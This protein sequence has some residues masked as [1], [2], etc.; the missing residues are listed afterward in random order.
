MKTLIP[1]FILLILTGCVPT[2][3][4]SYDISTVESLQDSIS[5]NKTF[6]VF[7]F[8]DIREE[9]SDTEI[10]FDSG[11]LYGSGSERICINAEKHYEEGKVSRQVSEMIYFH[12]RRTAVF[13]SMAMNSDKLNYALKGSIKR[14]YGEQKFSKRASAGAQFGLIGAL[15]TANIKSPGKMR[16]T[17]TNLH[18]VDNET[19]NEIPLE[20]IDLQF[21]GEYRIDAK[22]WFI[23]D[24][25]NER[26]KETIDLRLL[27]AIIEKTSSQH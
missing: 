17:L 15:A 16:I 1:L 7:N 5:I 26:L 27:P 21:E 3:K 11:N 8:D 9:V 2:K 25:V 22:C 6:S 12:I 19:G 13:D 14:L 23:Y 10:L 4:I 20:D 18:L 24:H